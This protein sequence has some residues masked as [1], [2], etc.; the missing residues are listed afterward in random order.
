MP[1]SNRE[2]RRRRLQQAVYE[3]NLSQSAVAWADE[4]P[5]TPSAIGTELTDDPQTSVR[6]RHRRR[7]QSGDESTAV[8]SHLDELVARVRATD[9]A[10]PVPP[11]ARA[12]PAQP[13]VSSFE[14]LESEQQLLNSPL[15]LDEADIYR[16]TAPPPV[17]VAAPPPP[18]GPA[19]T[20]YVEVAPTRPRHGQTRTFER[21]LPLARPRAEERVA[22]EP[23]GP[24]MPKWRSG[25]WPF[26]SRTPRA[27]VAAR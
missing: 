1:A 8:G 15:D 21:A 13:V 11:R 5:A 17:F 6:R 18:L 26:F 7:W 27:Q 25:I 2:L 10:M 14:L 9:Q 23:S 19:C 20:L 4:P 3:T 24:S 12:T 16:S 22:D